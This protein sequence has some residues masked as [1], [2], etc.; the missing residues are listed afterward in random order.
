[1]GCTTATH[2]SSHFGLKQAGLPHIGA[3]LSIYYATKLSAN[4]K[5]FA[6]LGQRPQPVVDSQFELVDVVTYLI[7]FG[8]NHIVIGNG[9]FAFT[10]D[11]V[12]HLAGLYQFVD[13]G[14]DGDFALGNVLDDFEVLGRETRSLL[15]LDRLVHAS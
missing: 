2:R 13:L 11:A 3:A 12:G 6:I 9:L 4:E 7:E 5:E 14:L 15:A 8:S 1:M 10:D